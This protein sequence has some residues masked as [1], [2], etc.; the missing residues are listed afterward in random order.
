M[1][2]SRTAAGGMLGLALLATAAAC[3][4][5]GLQP[6]EAGM[7]RLY[8]VGSPQ[9]VDDREIIAAARKYLDSGFFDVDIKALKQA[10]ETLPWVAQAQ[11]YRHW[12][13]GLIIKVRE[14]QPV[15]VWGDSAVLAKD[16][17]VFR[18]PEGDLPSGLPTLVGPE[19]AR[20][21]MWKK[22]SAL[23]KALAPLDASIARVDLS[24]RGSWSVVLADGL[25]LRLGRMHI[26][27]RA[28]RFAA[29]GPAAIGDALATAGYVDLRYDNGFAVGGTRA[30][31]GNKGRKG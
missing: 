15:A 9:H 6:S 20:E 27:H 12:P 1:G 29:Y 28:E 16:G 22:L 31:S 3:T 13:S 21:E 17:S 18:P 23:R 30:A 2:W 25:E 8:I 11:I 7:Q 4:W 10:V 5:Q 24:R 26:I 14:H 19:R